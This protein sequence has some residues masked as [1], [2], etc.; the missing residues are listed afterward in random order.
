[1]PSKLVP[2][3]WLC[4]AAAAAN[5]EWPPQHFERVLIPVNVTNAPGAG[6]S[7]WSVYGK[8]YI[9][10]EAGLTWGPTDGCVRPG[11]GSPE[12]LPSCDLG[13]SP[14]VNGM[15]PVG[16]YPTLSGETPGTYIYLS[17]EDRDKLQFA[18][19]IRNGSEPG[20]QIPVV[21]EEDFSNRMVRILDVP[22]RTTHRL[23]LRVYGADPDTL[24][25]VRVRIVREQYPDPPTVLHEEVLDLTVV[26]RY[27]GG[28]PVRPPY[29]QLSF[30]APLTSEDDTVRFELTPLS[31][32]LRIWAFVSA[33]D[34]RTQQVILRTPD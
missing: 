29:A 8:V 30:A 27:F 15:Y 26:Q 21:R 1:M 33:T 16:F 6:G 3:F 24:G 14:L 17:R 34:N 5:A 9:D 4:L 12:R 11:S 32:T 7:L 2:V 23:M 20:I 13:N 31:S 18:F 22:D 10:S 19:F 25:A 28:A